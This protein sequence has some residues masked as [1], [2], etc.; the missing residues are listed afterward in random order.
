[1]RRRPLL[2]PLLL[3]STG[4]LATAD[5]PPPA[6]VLEREVR[7]E[8]L[9]GPGN[10]EASGVELVDGQLVVAFDDDTRLAR[11]R[12]DLSGGELIGKPG[13][14]SDFE[15]VAWDPQEKR[16]YVVAEEARQPDGRFAPRLARFTA[17]LEPVGAPV[18]L[19]IALEGGNKGIEG[20]AFLRR[21]AAPG[22]PAREVLLCLYEGN[23][24]GAGKRGK[25][26]GHGQIAVLG[27]TP[28]DGWE[29]LDTLR[30]PPQAAFSDYAG[31]DLDGDRLAVVSQASERVWIGRL[32]PDAWQVVDAGRVYA[33]P[34]G[35]AR[36]EGIA[37]LDE[38][39]LVI[40]SDTAKPDEDASH[41]QSLHVFRLPE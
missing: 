22:Q 18:T 38:R 19:P 37:W 39:R 6:L 12:P 7:L 41:D 33:L 28:D 21:A 11:V 40:S 35:F 29:L 36:C 30:L 32:A 25:D 9:V 31:L 1:M 16:V 8:Q 26:Q 23:H 27:R 14:G 20:L 15:G 34:P 3:L 4:W 17:D 24:G 2:A 10:W 5:E 13:R